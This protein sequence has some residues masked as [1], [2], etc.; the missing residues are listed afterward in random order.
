MSYVW[1]QSGAIVQAYEP[2][3]SLDTGPAL[4]ARVVEDSAGHV[5]AFVLTF[6]LRSAC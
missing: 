4:D 6:G 2:P 3:R 5:L 1:T